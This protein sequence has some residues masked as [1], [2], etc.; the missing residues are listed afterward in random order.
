M[1]AKCKN[2]VLCE[3]KFLNMDVQ[4]DVVTKTENDHWDVGTVTS[5]V[6]EWEKIDKR[7]TYIN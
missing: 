1:A 3:V 2:L 7:N 5:R 6:D 4:I